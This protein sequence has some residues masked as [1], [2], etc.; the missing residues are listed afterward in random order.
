MILDLVD[1][2]LDRGIQL[3]AHGKQMRRELR[4]EYVRP[5]FS[6]F[7]QV[8][9]AYLQ[10]F[11]RYR[12]FIQATQEPSWVR[13]LQATL[14]REN[15]FSADSRSK[16]V[17]LAKAE[18]DDI[19]APFIKGICEYLMGARLVDPLGKEIDPVSVQRWRQGFSTTLGEIAEEQWQMVID[20]VGAMPPLSPKEMKRELKQLRKSYPVD[21]KTTTKQ[22]ALKRSCALWALDE[23]VSEMQQ[24]YNQ[25]SQS[26][27]ELDRSLSK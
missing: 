23:I 15:L 16:V 21:S 17:Q 5:V 22:D 3:L 9:S 6:E 4:D 24:Q 26:Y 18:N 11:S 27:A 20:P 7:E 25:I 10:S 13:D 12:D 1:K 8:H 14:R 19:L 2:L